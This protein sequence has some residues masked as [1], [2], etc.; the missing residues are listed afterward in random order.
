MK[1][2]VIVLIAV[3]LVSAFIF[4]A[5][6]GKKP[7]S[8]DSAVTDLPTEEPEITWCPG[9]SDHL[10]ICTIDRV[11][12]VYG[13]PEVYYHMLYASSSNDET[14]MEIDCTSFF[15][16]LPSCRDELP[17]L[18]VSE[19]EIELRMPDMC[20]ASIKQADVYLTLPSGEIMLVNF[21]TLD[22]A[23][24]YASDHFEDIDP[25]PVID[26]IMSYSHRYV[27]GR[28]YESGEE[29]YAFVLIP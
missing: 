25:A 14:G 26:V 11:T 6:A 5:C 29:G 27:K 15:E 16:L 8:H 1:R 4:S 10:I 22:E 20:S 13:E 2:T 3:L 9:S 12:G 24:S 18:S 7:G 17:K 28:G 19:S 23:L 21:P